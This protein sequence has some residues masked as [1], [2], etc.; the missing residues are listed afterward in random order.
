[1]GTLCRKIQKQLS[2]GIKSAKTYQSGGRKRFV[3][4]R[5]LKESEPG[6]QLVVFDFI[7]L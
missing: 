4:T 1:M 6:A 2:A 7:F 5:H 3:G